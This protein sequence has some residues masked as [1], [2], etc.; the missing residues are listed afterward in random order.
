MA[1]RVANA[2]ENGLVLIF[3]TGQSFLPPWMPIHW[4]VRV[5]LKIRTGL[6][7]QSIHR[8]MELRYLLRI[9]TYNN[10]ETK[11][12]ERRKHLFPVTV[13]FTSSEML[14]REPFFI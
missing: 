12:Q 3:G 6:V 7:N 4:I 13:V 1:G 2:E 5:L 14:L 11:S 9:L 10:W 8:L